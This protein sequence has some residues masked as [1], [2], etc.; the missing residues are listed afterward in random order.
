MVKNLKKKKRTNI[1]TTVVAL[2]GMPPSLCA[3]LLVVL[4]GEDYRR[5]HERALVFAGVQGRAVNLVHRKHVLEA[6][7]VPT[8]KYSVNERK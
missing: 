3:P 4:L 6:D 7:V 8:K 2:E 5:G 1:L